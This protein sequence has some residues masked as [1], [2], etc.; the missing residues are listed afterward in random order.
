[1]RERQGLRR[2]EDRHPALQQRVVEASDERI[3]HHQSCA[4]RETDAVGAVAREQPEAVAQRGERP[5]GVEKMTDVRAVDHHAA[6]QHELGQRRVQLG[7]VLAQNRCVERHRLEHASRQ[8]R[9]LEGR[10]VVRVMRIGA[11]SNRGVILQESNHLG[12]RRDERA[13]AHLVEPVAENRAQ[14]AQR[15]VGTVAARRAVARVWNPHRAGGAR[16]RAAD[17]IGLLYQ[18]HV[19]TEYGG[20]ER[21]GHAGRAAADYEKIDLPLIAHGVRSSRGLATLAPRQISQ[22]KR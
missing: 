11:E 16:A 6:E 9:A 2:E 1:M 4:A 14:I 7:E 17:N 22:S 5:R 20:G 19:E 21:R 3:A 15:I 18:Q 10:P 8:G 13:H 12:S